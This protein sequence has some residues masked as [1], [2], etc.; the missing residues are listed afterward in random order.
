MNGGFRSSRLWVIFPSIR[1]GKT[2]CLAAFRTCPIKRL[3]SQIC[4]ADQKVVSRIQYK[5]D[6]HAKKIHSIVKGHMIYPLEA[7]IA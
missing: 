6:G 4:K 2:R 3:C 7:I 1:V 5:R